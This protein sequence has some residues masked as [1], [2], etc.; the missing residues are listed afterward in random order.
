M[1]AEK[2]G[3]DYPFLDRKELLTFEEITQVATVA[4]SLGVTKIRLTGGEPL[5]R[6]KIDD[7]V[8]MLA[9]IPGIQDIALTTNGV[10]L[11]HYADR[12][13][14]A[15]LSRVTVSLDAI[16]PET[17]ATMNGVG[18]DV[19]RVL[20]GIEA[21][22]EAGLPIKINSVIKKSINQ[23]EVLPLATYARQTGVHLRFIEFMD[24][25]ETNQ[26]SL[27]EVLPA[28]EIVAQL[29]Q[30]YGI[31]PEK[32]PEGAVA[33]EFVYRDGRCKVGIIRSV[34][35]PFCHDCT[36]LRLSAQGK[37]YGCLFAATGTDIKGTLRNGA[38]SSD[39]E[40]LLRNFWS[41]RSDRYSELRGKVTQKK[42]EM[43]YIGG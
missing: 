41:R 25:G 14:Q 39:L 6:R 33:E 9:S 29:D 32:R 16:D 42:I 10:S 2:F 7:L 13:K 1:P 27:K 4:A 23:Q 28:H 40:G 21:A 15:G 19:S 24:V 31:T 8:R 3:A 30:E 20:A 26:W 35:Q 18:A 43:S 36:R 12:L 37:L 5:L 11:G 38:S 22:Q 17:F 34:S